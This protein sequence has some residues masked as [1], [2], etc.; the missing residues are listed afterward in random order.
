MDLGKFDFLLS[1]KKQ[2]RQERQGVEVAD[3]CYQ[4]PETKEYT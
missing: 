4:K 2:G 3:K 1:V